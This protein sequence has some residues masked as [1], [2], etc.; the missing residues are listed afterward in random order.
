ME[1]GRLDAVG[2]QFD[3]YSV[4]LLDR[5][6]GFIQPKGLQIAEFQ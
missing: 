4:V 6:T 1:T 2:R 3:L 5:I